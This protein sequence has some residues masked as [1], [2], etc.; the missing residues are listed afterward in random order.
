[1]KVHLPVF[2]G[3]YYDDEMRVFPDKVLDVGVYL[4]ISSPEARKNRECLIIAPI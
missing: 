3:R 2:V 1:M 4:C